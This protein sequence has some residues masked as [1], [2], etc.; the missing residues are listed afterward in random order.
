MASPCRGADHS[1]VNL[2]AANAGT[3]EPRLFDER[4][5]PDFRETYGRLLHASERLDVALTHIRLSTLDLGGAEL[6]RVR[7]IRLLLAEVSAAQ[8]DAEAHAVMLRSDKRETL[9][10]LT[11][12]LAAG[13]I[14]VRSAPLGGWSPDFS[15]FRGPDG[16]LAVLLGFHWFERP[17]PHRGPAFASL[18][19]SVPANAALT[20]FEEAWER[21]HDIGP[22]VLGILER[23]ER[24]ENRSAASIAGG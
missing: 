13:A 5:W 16:P 11:A 23:A 19:G 2:L 12:R 22:A 20:R 1:R 4:A 7:D 8:L 3:V 18:H 14:Q 10:S 6:G 21:G 9:R 24:A 17:F 15:I